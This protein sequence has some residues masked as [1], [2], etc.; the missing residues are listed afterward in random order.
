MRR[1]DRLALLDTS[2]Y[3]DTAARTQQ[4]QALSRAASI[5]GS[6]S[7]ISQNL[8]A[9]YVH[10]DRLG[11]IALTERIREMTQ[12]VGRDEFLRQNAMERPDGREILSK[13]LCPSL[14]LC[15]HDDQ[16][17]P[18]AIHEE[19]AALMPRARL[20]TVEACGHMAPMERPDQVSVA[21]RDWLQIDPAA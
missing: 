17:T 7:G 6:F 8:L 15:G 11:D 1:V 4:R 20:R 10:P 2:M 18:R 9:S 16:I 14:V 21:L 5:S 12:R 3:A 19:M 13:V